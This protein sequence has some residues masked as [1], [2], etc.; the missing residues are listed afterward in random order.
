MKVLLVN[1]SP[2]AAGSTYTALHE[3]EQIFQAN[4]IETELLQVGKQDI[5]GCVAV[6][7]VQSSANAHFLIW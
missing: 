3:M 1:G 4:G 7:P 5:R 2:H 6:M